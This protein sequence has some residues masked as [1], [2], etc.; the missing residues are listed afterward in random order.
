MRR[1]IYK[2]P[3]I[4]EALCE[5]HFVNDVEWDPMSVFFFHKEIADS[6]PETPTRLKSAETTPYTQGN[7][8]RQTYFLDQKSARI[9]F[10]D[11]Y[12]KNLVSIGQNVVSVHMLR[13]YQTWELFSARI[14]EILNKYDSTIPCKGI[15]RIG[16]RYINKIGIDHDGGVN[17]Q[18]YFLAIPMLPPGISAGITGF[19]DRTELIYDDVPIKLTIVFADTDF[20]INRATFLLDLDLTWEFG[21]HPIRVDQAMKKVEILRERERNIFEGMITNKLRKIFDAKSD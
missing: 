13:P 9:Q 1:R 2:N 17:L 5:F 6:Y 14:E 3:P 12:K 11:V 10:S 18:Q 16:L 7:Q 20:Q 4:E 21:D 8:L 15:R 19:F